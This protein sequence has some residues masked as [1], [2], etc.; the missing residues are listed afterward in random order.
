[1]TTEEMKKNMSMALT[2]FA[3]ELTKEQLDYCVRARPM[4]VLVFCAEKL[5]EEQ[6]RY[7]EKIKKEKLLKDAVKTIKKRYW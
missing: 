4:T 6:K 2:S 3:D 1:M 5:T 7:C